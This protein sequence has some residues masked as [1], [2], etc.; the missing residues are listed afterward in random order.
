MAQ[1]K[2][3]LIDNDVVD[4]MM[5]SYLDTN[6]YATESYVVTAISNI[7][8]VDLTGYATESY[9]TT[10]VSNLVDAAPGTL[11]TLNELAAALGDDP[12]FA[13]TITN[14]IAGKLSL[15]GGTISGDLTVTGQLSAATVVETSSIKL[16]TN[17][18]QIN[19][20]LDSVLK[21]K[22]V[23]YDRI[24]NN[25][26]EAGLIAEW[27]EDILPDLVIKDA[28]S[29]IIGIKYTKLTAYLIEAIKELKQEIDLLK[30]K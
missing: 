21:L 11:D 29:N 22:G 15:T 3:K 8:A 12:D 23:T 5:Q 16:K 25:E 9:V 6:N 4:G 7:P 24:D 10:A 27:T 26:H 28:G 13:T 20:A 30:A 17:I 1:T 14:S 19:D 18:E 2:V